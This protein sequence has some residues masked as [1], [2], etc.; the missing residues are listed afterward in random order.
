MTEPGMA[1]Y[2][3]SELA[4]ELSAAT[5]AM[6]ERLGVTIETPLRAPDTALWTALHDAGFADIVPTSDAET[7]RDVDA[8]AT[9]ADVLA[10]VATLAENGAVTPYIEHTVMATWLASGIGH[11]IPEG[12][13]ATVAIADDHLTIDAAGL[14]HGTIDGVVFA[15]A[16]DVVVIAVP[17]A[18]ESPVDTRNSGATPTIIVVNLG[19]DGV[20]R[21]AG[22][23]LVGVSVADLT[24]AGTLPSAT[25]NAAVSL[26]DIMTRGALAY[27]TSIAAAARAVATR[28]VRYTGERIQFGRPLTKFQAVQHGLA[29]MS[30]VATMMEI[31]VETATRTEGDE[32]EIAVAAAKVVTSALAQDVAA[33]GH[34]LHGA[35]GFTAEHPLGRYT[36]ALWT[37]RDRYGTETHWADALA[38]RIL[39]GA[40]P[41]DLI[42]G[43]DA[44]T[45]PTAPVLNSDAPRAD[46]R[47]DR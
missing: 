39:T 47:S 27:A 24:F 9:L 20:Q 30:A 28:T 25:G 18:D 15:D 3:T 29:S 2:A 22:T 31:A 5:E 16:A 34:Q 17:N 8:D 38:D 14:L 43:A 21:S 45:A 40:D 41:W 36:A 7:A 10:V 35:I 42:T 4:T 11:R 46:E 37:W 6:I 23:D 12:V 13:T 33:T 19:A 26:A 32:H 1:R 44:V